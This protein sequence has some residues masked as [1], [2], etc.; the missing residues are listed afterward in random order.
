MNT[1][2]FI[3]TIQRLE[4]EI[5]T[6]TAPREGLYQLIKDSGGDH[7]PRLTSRSDRYNIFLFDEPWVCP[8]SPGRLVP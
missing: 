6:S 1:S 5:I 3:R 7:R 2:A 4:H 8:H